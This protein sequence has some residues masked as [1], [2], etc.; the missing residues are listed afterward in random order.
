MI[1]KKYL[2]LNKTV[3]DIHAIYP[4]GYNAN[5]YYGKRCKSYTIPIDYVKAQE[6]HWYVEVESEVESFKLYSVSCKAGIAEIDK[7]YHIIGKDD[8]D[9]EYIT[10]KGLTNI[11]HD[12]FQIWIEVKYTNGNI[13]SF[14]TEE[15]ELNFC[16][17]FDIVYSC[18]NKDDNGGYD[19][20]GAWIGLPNNPYAVDSTGNV[21]LRYFNNYTLRDL[22][23]LYSGS[24]IT[25]TAFKNR[26]VK[27]ERVKNYSVYTEVIPYWYEEMIS[28]AFSKGYVFID[29]SYYSITEYSSVPVGDVCCERVTLNIIATEVNSVAVSCSKECI[30]EDLELPDCFIGTLSYTEDVI[31]KDCEIGNMSYKTIGVEVQSTG[32]FLTLEEACTSEGIS[33]PVYVERLPIE[34]GDFMY[35]DIYLENKITSGDPF[36][37]YYTTIDGVPYSINLPTGAFIEELSC[38]C[39]VNLEV[40]LEEINNN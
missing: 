37:T 13:R 4:E 7:N 14:F 17:T 26:A 38:D 11:P 8:S 9:Q 2:E 21:N 5:C 12:I 15:Y 35:Y 20:N 34:P 28:S 25:Y 40:T 10:W 23:V 32:I 39:G 1:L 29:G 19:M 3:A 27:S 31:E 33:I 18:Y 24:Q 36:G 16:D 22:K 30:I 6:L